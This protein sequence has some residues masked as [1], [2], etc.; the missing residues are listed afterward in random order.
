[1]YKTPYY[2]EIQEETNELRVN[3]TNHAG[4]YNFPGTQEILMKI[5]QIETVYTEK[6]KE[7][8]KEAASLR[9]DQISFIKAITNDLKKDLKS[10][11]E[12]VRLE[13]ERVLLGVVIHRYLRLIDSY[14]PKLEASLG[15]ALTFFTSK[16][17]YKDVSSC[18]LYNTLHELFGFANLDPYT[19]LFC[20][21]A[22]QNYLKLDKCKDRYAYINKD[23]YFFGKLNDIIKDAKV[24]TSF[25][26]VPIKKQLAYISYIESMGVSLSV[27]DKKVARLIEQLSVL[28]MNR[29]EILEEVGYID[30]EKLFE[31]LDKLKP[32][33]AIRDI[34]EDFVPNLAITKN[35][36]MQ[37]PD[38]EGQWKE[39]GEFKK[40]LTTCL[41]VHS[42]NILLGAYLLCL[43]QCNEEDTPHLRAALC[44]AISIN[45]SNP[46]NKEK[47]ED[48]ALI[49]KTLDHLRGFMR[50]GVTDKV[51]F[52]V[53][54]DENQMMRVLTQLK[55]SY[56]HEPKSLVM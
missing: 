19:I 17:A 25:A 21:K 55:G 30:R 26:K 40:V 23:P 31:D 18:E 52:A 10:E 24:N 44:S 39:D 12:E 3:F 28:I 7:Q 50:R 41:A 27:T 36:Q 45:D 32:T 53:W 33:P 43:S 20:S 37:T 5:E 42:K 56:E 16:V 29:L 49:I 46:L 1:M 13:A 15:S 14:K 4:L 11:N 54:G 51:K 47:E 2:K 35:G 22:L 48:K 38:N 8:G 34:F 9:L 6:A